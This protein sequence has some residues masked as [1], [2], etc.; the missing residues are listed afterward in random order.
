MFSTITVY[1]SVLKSVNIGPSSP[2]REGSA[3]QGSIYDVYG[4]FRMLYAES[5]V[6]VVYI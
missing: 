3:F 2:R 1:F 4:M 6:Q 5:I